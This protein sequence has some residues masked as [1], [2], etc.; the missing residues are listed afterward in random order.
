MKPSKPRAPRPPAF[1]VVSI[2]RDE[3]ARLPRMLASIEAFRSRGGD[4]V[5]LDT[6][7]ADGTVRVAREAGCRVF[8]E[9]T[10]FSGRLTGTQARRIHRTFVK[11]GETAFLEAGQRLFGMAAARNH[12][13]SLARRPFQLVLDGSDV[14]EAMD[15]D[16]LDATARSREF[17]SLHFES[18]DLGPH[19]WIL[20]TREFLY[21]R[22]R[23]AWAGRAQ[24]Y[25]VSRTPRAVLKRNL[26]R[27]DQLFVSHH[28][29]LEKSRG[30]QVAAHAL[31]ALADPASDRWAY[32]L[33]RALLSRGYPR[34][35]YP[36]L[37]RLDRPES[38]GPL[39]A[40]GL[41]MAAQCLAASEGKSD[42]IEGLLL[43]ASKWNPNSRDPWLHLASRC[44]A[45]GDMQGAASFAAAALAVPGRPGVMEPEANYGVRPHEILYWSLLWLGR[46]DEARAHFEICRAKDPRNPVYPTHEPLFAATAGAGSAAPPKAKGRG[47][48]RQEGAAWAPKPR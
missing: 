7:S 28:T 42:D 38:P 14:V 35:A 30:R 47:H 27:R 13:A 40:A 9:P 31:D 24:S 33:G 23:V 26:L 32:Y 8:V 21:D 16:F 11:G 37:L 5:I 45:G 17:S 2:V 1:S 12:A 19:G 25:L 22:R 4:I 18:R 29:D 3:E 39:R 46:R 10:R 20:G 44:L 36:L 34:S 41:C 15:L 43:R 6:G 48:L